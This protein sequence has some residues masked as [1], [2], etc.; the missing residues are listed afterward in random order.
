[1]P[2]PLVDPINLRDELIEKASRGVITNAE[3]EAEAERLGLGAFERAPDAANFDPAKLGT[4]TIPMAVSWIAY[5]SMDAVREAWPAYCEECWYWLWQRWRNGPDGE[6][7]EGWILKQRAFPTLDHVNMRVLIGDDEDRPRFMPFKDAR[8]A[9]WD[10]LS[11]AMLIATAIPRQGGERV[12]IA[13]AEWL[14]L[15]V[16]ESHRRDELGH[17]GVLAYSDTRVPSKGVRFLWGPPKPARS[18]PELMRPDGDGFMPIFCAAQWIAT[19]GGAKTFDPETVE[20]WR[21]AFDQ[22]LAAIASERVR[23]V[24]LHKGARERVPP[25]TFAGC[26]VDYPYSDAPLS[27]IMGGSMYLR[28]YPYIDDPHWRDGFDDA[29][30][31]RDGD[32]WTQLQVEKGD[33]RQRWPFSGGV[34]QRRPFDGPATQPRSGAPGRPSS[35]FLVLE[36][37]GRIGSEGHLETTATAQAVAL[38][39]WLSREHRDMPP[40]TPK[41]IRNK[42]A[43]EFR[44]LVAARK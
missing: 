27:L 7:F 9:L 3:A 12:P 10:A 8:Q 19:E 35:M 14:T 41:T 28:S 11:E 43:S 20:I 40:L 21:A 31:N 32:H 29:L 36:E 1:M 25:A 23:A 13:A 38:A 42:I 33:V 4:W 22:L 17:D 24:G 18:L 2:P 15:R 5:R 34:Q 44:A 37:L 16:K 6:I 39:E 30:V 26:E